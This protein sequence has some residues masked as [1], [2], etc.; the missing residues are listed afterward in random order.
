[1]EMDEIEEPYRDNNKDAVHRQQGK[2]KICHTE[3]NAGPVVNNRT[4]SLS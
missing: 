1:M 4:T 3:T 2:I